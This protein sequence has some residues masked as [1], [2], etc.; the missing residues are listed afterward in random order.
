MANAQ[1]AGAIPFVASAHE[2]T[3][4][5]PS[6]T[7]QLVT[8]TGPTPLNFTIPSTGFIRHVWLYVTLT[9]GVNG[10]NTVAAT[11]DTPWNVLDQ[12][13]FI[14]TN[15]APIVGPLAGYSLFA[16]NLFG[17]YTY[18]SDPRCNP[19]YSPISVG[20]SGTGNAAFMVRVPIELSHHDATGCLGNQNAAA[21]YR[22][23]VNV[24][25]P[26]TLFTT[27]PGTLPLVTVQPVLETWT[28]PNA[29][30]AMGRP[31]SQFPPNY[32]TVQYWS[33]RNQ[34]PIG[35]G[36]DTARVLRVGNLIRNVI[37]ICRDTSF[38][39]ARADTAFPTQ[40][41][42]SWDDRNLTN[43]PQAYRAARTAE[44]M[45]T[46]PT[47]SR[48]TGV[49]AYTFDRSNQDRAGDDKPWGWI[50]TVE[51]TRLE[52]TGNWTDSSYVTILVN[53]IAPGEVNPTQRYVE[54]SATGFHPDTDNKAGR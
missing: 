6:Q 52:L 36:Q 54:T 7:V 26:A 10:T 38:T 13:T 24:A 27:A 28:L 11:G 35:S 8:A 4:T 23:T 48:P 30:D 37:F 22:L 19:V 49:F 34:G 16:A 15:S 5:I 1:M 43:E 31:Q 12:L 44:V 32:G 51:A 47:L 45:T 17:G 9:G 53:D 40:P 33:Q 14:D 3:E 20:A 39:G 50:P 42:L 18:Q 2:H 29:T 41:I 21:P 46:I 25:A